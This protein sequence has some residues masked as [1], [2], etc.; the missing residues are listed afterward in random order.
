MITRISDNVLHG[1]SPLGAGRA[2]FSLGS[3]PGIKRKIPRRRSSYDVSAE[4]AKLKMHGEA[5]DMER[6]GNRTKV[7][8]GALAAA[9]G[10]KPGRRSG[11]RAVRGRGKDLAASTTRSR[12]TR[13]PG[14]GGRTAGGGQGRGSALSARLESE[15]ADAQ[16]ALD[17]RC[18]R[19]DDAQSSW[20]RLRR[21]RRQAGGLLDDARFKAGA[22][23]KEAEGARNAARG[24]R[25]GAGR[26]APCQ[27]T[28]RTKGR[29]VDRSLDA[30]KTVSAQDDEASAR[31]DALQEKLPTPGGPGGKA[32]LMDEA[33]RKADELNRPS[34]PPEGRGRGEAASPPPGGPG[35]QGGPPDE[36]RKNWPRPGGS[37]T[38]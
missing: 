34:P 16:A 33:Q 13:H 22:A 4:T 38:N 8:I 27:G 32:A 5:V 36:T 2:A 23:Q 19:V 24:R 35:R 7:L 21:V 12:R 3:M 29:E 30:L 37:L 28:A 6:N 14:K 25:I 26:G 11:G 9:C 10:G 1:F 15:K 17:L 18:R 20:T 31:A